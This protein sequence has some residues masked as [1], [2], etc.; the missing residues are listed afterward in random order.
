M[1]VAGEIEMTWRVEIF[2]VAKK[3]RAARLS[4]FRSK[5]KKNLLL[6]IAMGDFGVEAA[7]G[8]RFLDLFPEHDGTVLAAGTANS[9][10]QIAFAFADVMRDEVG[11]EAFDAAKKFAGLREGTDIFLDLEIFAGE[12]A[13]GRDKVGVGKKAHVEDEVG[14]RR[15]AV[16]V[17]KADDGN[18]HG[19]VVGIFEAFRDEVTKLVDV[20]L[21]G[22]DDD[23]G[24]FADGLH[25]IA[26]MT[27][28]FSNGKGLAKRMRAAGLAEA[29]EQS[30]V[31]GV[32]ENES[33]GVILAEMFKE[34][35]EFFELHPFARVD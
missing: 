24:E 33:D 35:R 11:E 13:Q 4:S 27:E 28:A 21:G 8:E 30:V 20:E 23:I 32:D 9:D 14:V 6:D 10:G 34:G 29:A 25:E 18:E 7:L 19:A 26:F 16:F 17:A 5:T 1:G 12:A 31:A 22:V 15:N 2:K 3:P